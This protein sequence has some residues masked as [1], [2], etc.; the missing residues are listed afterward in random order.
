MERQRRQR[1]TRLLTRA[2]RRAGNIYKVDG[3]A[4]PGSNQAHG[5]PKGR[6]R[7]LRLTRARRRSTVI[8]NYDVRLANRRRSPAQTKSLLLGRLRS[9]SGL[10]SVSK[11]LKLLLHASNS[12]GQN[13]DL[14]HRWRR[15]NDS[16]RSFL[17]SG[18]MDV[19]LK[20]KDYILS[21]LLD[22]SLALNRRTCKRPS[23]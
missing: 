8:R 15:S 21:F 14:V 1:R 22:Q 17:L 10:K 11:L 18:L 2:S 16:L 20:V 23:R 6:R 12:Q 9:G 3:S 4:L 19:I 5:Q 7:R 13:I